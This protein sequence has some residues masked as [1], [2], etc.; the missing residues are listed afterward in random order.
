MGLR[1]IFGVLGPGFITGAS[2][3]DPAGIATYS[4][5]GAMFGY[6]L[7]WT[8]L[9]TWPLMT[10]V[11]YISGRIGAATGKGLAG[12]LKEHYPR[13][14]LYC[15]AVLLFAANTIN[16][17]ADIGAMAAAA[18][19]IVP[20]N[21]FV[22]IVGFGVLIV[23]LISFLSYA[24][25]SRYLKWLSLSLLAYVASAAASGVDWEKALQDI[26]VPS[27]ELDS[28][29]L[30]M[31][32]AILGTTISPYLAFWESSQEVERR[33]DDGD[34]DPALKERPRRGRKEMR[35][36]RG[37]TMFGMATSNVIGIFI[38]L[39]CAATL[40]QH[41]KT[42][43]QSAA[44]AAAA[45]KPIAGQLTSVIFAAGIV[46]TGLLAVPVLAG[47]AAFALGE[48]FGWKIGLDLTPKR[49]K[50]FYAVIA[51]SAAIGIALNL[52]Q[53]NIIQFL[54]AT[55]IINGVVELP[56]ILMMMLIARNR[57]IMGAFVTPPLWSVLG[58]A[59][60]IVMGAAA[61]GMVATF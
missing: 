2:D 45:L 47:S 55:A 24:S 31:I 27:F 6:A 39:T 19:L 44:E 25:Y 34:G 12:N 46:G 5:T 13:W 15:L 18:D 9:Y 58:W 4:Q 48:G 56:V 22:F 16:V 30:A 11:H 10:A 52:L 50:A 26:F 14:I 53:V 7:A 60:L 40:N 49:A 20:L 28:K 38:M 33:K 17:G 1:K 54:V 59:T 41:G 29:M 21:R 8:E 32:V 43:I 3:D 51:L 57:R 42:D 35:R 37:D 23:L 61:M 36:L